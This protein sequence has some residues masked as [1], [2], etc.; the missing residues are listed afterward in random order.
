MQHSRRLNPGVSHYVG[1]M[2][3]VRLGETFD[4]VLIHDSLDYMTT[5]VEL[6]GS[7]AR[8]SF[9]RL[10]TNGGKGRPQ[11]SPLR[12]RVS[13]TGLGVA[14]GGLKT[15]GVGDS[16]IAPTNGGGSLCVAALEGDGHEDA[17]GDGEED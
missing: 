1:D 16:R 4:A 7:R 8:G 11:G 9:D 13:G 12:T 2:R 6:R 3:S 5:E 10:S 15:N 14:F 17:D